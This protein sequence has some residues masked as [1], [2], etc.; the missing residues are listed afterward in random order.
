MPRNDLRIDLNL[1]RVLQAIHLHGGVGAA[2]RALHLTQPAVTHALGRLR[3]ALDDPLFVRQGNRL[4]PTARTRAMMPAVQAHLE[5]LLASAHARPAFD[6]ARL[7][8]AFEVGFRDILES[9]VLPG[10]LARLGREAPGV[11]VASRRIA[12]GGVERDLAA[13]SIDLAVDRTLQAGASVLRRKL[14]NDALVVLAR[15]RHPLLPRLDRS[16]YLAAGH[17]AVAAP[18]ETATLD[19]MLGQRGLPRHIRMTC[20]HH[21]PAAQVAA[22]TDL[23][24]SLPR[25]HALQLVRLLPLAIAELPVRLKSFPVLAYWHR[26]VDADPAQ[27][28]FRQCVFEAFDAAMEA[29]A[30]AIRP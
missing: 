11:R 4:Q 21:F 15:R 28:W 19:L 20:Q 18:G 24:L 16:A 14:G 13:G 3:Q 27:A 25:S 26:S 12:T 5:G 7:E 17:V 2:A 30:K 22:R 9:L 10:L 29:Q 8:M 1:F 6:P 23:L